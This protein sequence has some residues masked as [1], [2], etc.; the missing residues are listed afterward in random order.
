MG[1]NALCARSAHRS[2]GLARLTTGMS[3]PSAAEIGA[4]AEAI[5]GYRSRTAGLA[6]PL[7]GSPNEDLLA[8]LFEAERTL[9]NALR[10]LHRA[11]KLAR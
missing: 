11:E 5:E 7:I 10:A 1:A 6:E 8:S 4:I 2:P 9:R 3:S